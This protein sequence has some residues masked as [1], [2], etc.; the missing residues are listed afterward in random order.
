L[1]RDSDQHHATLGRDV[2]LQSLPSALIFELA[3]G[4]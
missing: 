3:H 1:S 2:V 4:Q